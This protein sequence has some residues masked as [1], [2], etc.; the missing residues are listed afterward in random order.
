MI[1]VLLC[2]KYWGFDCGIEIPVYSYCKIRIN[3]YKIQVYVGSS[4][5]FS[6]YGCFIFGY[7]LVHST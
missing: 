3:G 7:T 2:G 5:K 6:N 1:Y 4:K